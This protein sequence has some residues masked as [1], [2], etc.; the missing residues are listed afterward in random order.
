MR[1]QAFCTCKNKAADQLVSDLVPYPEDRLSH[2]KAHMQ[3]AVIS[4]AVTMDNFRIKN[5]ACFFSHFCSKHTLCVM[6]RIASLRR[7]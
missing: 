7:F 1:K 2:D 4:T 5:S 6:I 3:Y